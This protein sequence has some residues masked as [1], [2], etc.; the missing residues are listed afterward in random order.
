MT[1]IRRDGIGNGR[2]KTELNNGELVFVPWTFGHDGAASLTVSNPFTVQNADKS[3]TYIFLEQFAGGFGTNALISGYFRGRSFGVRFEPSQSSATLPTAHSDFGVMIDRVGYRVAKPAFNP[4]TQGRQLDPSG[5]YG[6]VV[7]RDL[8]DGLH[9]FEID[10]RVFASKSHA[11]YCL[12][13]LLEK[14]AGYREPQNFAIRSNPATV[15]TSAGAMLG[16]FASAFRTPRGISEVT[17][18]NTTGSSINVT[19]RLNS[20]DYF[21]FSIAAGESRQFLFNPPIAGNHFS[22]SAQNYLH[23][24][25]ATGVT[26]TAVGV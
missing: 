16:G 18:Y 7:T 3:G 6:V 23:L 1:S 15:G 25:S 4:M 26:F 11:L 19:W 9:H 20:V 24:A 13:L 21:V 5:S 8:C 22:N 17:Y 12:G 14:A 2:I 10:T